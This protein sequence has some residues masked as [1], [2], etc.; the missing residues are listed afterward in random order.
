MDDLNKRFLDFLA[1]NP[2]I[3][4]FTALREFTGYTTLYGKRKDAAFENLEMLTN[5]Q[6]PN[7]L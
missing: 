5:D 4:F 2:G 7:K 6:I 3:P 1:A